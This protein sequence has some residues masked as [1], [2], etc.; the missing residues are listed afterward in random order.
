[1]TILVTILVIIVVT[2]L[3][4]GRRNGLVRIGGGGV[5]GSRDYCLR[6]RWWNVVIK[7][8]NVGSHQRRGV[9]CMWGWCGH[10]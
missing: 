9:Q 5:L 8:R 4:S 10:V 2:I 6:L 1:M 7:L 3:L